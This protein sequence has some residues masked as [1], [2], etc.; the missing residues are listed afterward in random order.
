M[1][2]AMVVSF[3]KLPDLRGPRVFF[4]E[5]R[6]PIFQPVSLSRRHLFDGY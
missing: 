2:I 1:T 3:A 4:D 6:V 5:I